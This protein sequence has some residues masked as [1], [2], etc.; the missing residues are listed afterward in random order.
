MLEGNCHL[1]VENKLLKCLKQ[2][3]SLNLLIF[4]DM[5]SNL[6]ETFPTVTK[7]IIEVLKLSLKQIILIFGIS[8]SVQTDNGP[9][10]LLFPPSLWKLEI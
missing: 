1:R 9:S 8:N 10:F 5:F 4:R 3:I 7:K 2:G 6:W